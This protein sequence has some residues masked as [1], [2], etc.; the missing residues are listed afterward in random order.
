MKNDDIFFEEYPTRDLFMKYKYFKKRNRSYLSREETK[1]IVIN[2]LEVMCMPNFLSSYPENVYNQYILGEL[3]T[4]L[5]NSASTELRHYLTKQEITPITKRSSEKSEFFKG[6][7]LGLEGDYPNIELKRDNNIYSFRNAIPL[8]ITDEG[9]INGSN[10]EVSFLNESELRFSASV[11]LSPK[12]PKCHFYFDNY[13][14]ALI[15]K[16]AFRGLS[17]QQLVDLMFEL[18]LIGTLKHE[19][20]TFFS[21][22]DIS[23]RS[24]RFNKFSDNIVDFNQLYDKID[25]NDQL[26]MRTLFYLV[27][28]RMLWA[29]MCF[30]EDAISNVLFSIEGALLLLQRKAGYSDSKIDIDLLTKIF[31]DSFNR[32]EELFDFIREGYDKRI[33]IVHAYPKAGVEWTPILVAE[34]FY[35]YFDISRM[36]LVYV[37]L[38]KLIDD[39]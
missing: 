35:E 34:D 21:G 8:L 10:S 5:W 24:F 32:G 17:N 1:S 23:S 33:S 37:I 18:L 19:R 29:N 22:Q 26:T 39:Y 4:V 30:G 14:V 7:L 2:T 27:K 15:D 11:I 13:Y 36:L 28:S 3:A 6:R 12:Y 20:P 31:S 38:N 16:K 25:I 9:S